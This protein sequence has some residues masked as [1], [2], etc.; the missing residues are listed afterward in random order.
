MPHKNRLPRLF[1]T[2]LSAVT[3]AA[4]AQADH[5]AAAAAPVKADSSSATAALDEA[6][7]PGFWRLMGSPYTIHW[8][9]DE[10]GIH[11]PVY[12]IGLE[13]QRSDGWVWGGTY[14]SNSFGQPSV[15]VY[16]GEKVTHFTRWDGLF[17]Q[18]TALI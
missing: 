5:T 18:W 16:F 3:L 4:W 14:F 1:A 7:G 8:G 17:F 12:M 9:S 15:Y 11:E 13:R 10:E 6:I 2:L